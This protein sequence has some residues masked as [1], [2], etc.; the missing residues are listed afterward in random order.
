MGFDPISIGTAA[1]SGFGAYQNYRAGQDA[2]A[3]YNAQAK[4]IERQTAYAQRMA[5]EQMKDLS[6]EGRAAQSQAKA[7]AGK[8]G[9]RVAGSVKTLSQAIA[10]KV[11][12]RKALIGMETN[13]M[14][15]RGQVEA[16]ELRKAGRRVAKARTIKAFDSL[17]TGGIDLAQRKEKKGWGWGETF[18]RPRPRVTNENRATMTRY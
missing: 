2:K 16:G 9:V 4:E 10:D 18:Y 11:E 6:R 15:R 14:A 1:S 5:L 13:E 3:V 17:L 7:A 8:S 12:R